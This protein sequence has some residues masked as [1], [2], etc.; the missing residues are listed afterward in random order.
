MSQMSEPTKYRTF[1][2]CDGQLDFQNL[3]K[4]LFTVGLCVETSN[5]QLAL[6][7]Q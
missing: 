3:L 2:N 7:F 6:N 4:I 5:K 1:Y